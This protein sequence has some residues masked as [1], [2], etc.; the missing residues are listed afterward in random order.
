MV[1]VGLR[2]GLIGCGPR[3]LSVFERL[4]SICEDRPHQPVTIYIFDPH[5]HGSGVHWPKQPDYLLLNTISGQLGVFPDAAALGGLTD[6]RERPGKDFLTWCRG[7][8]IKVDPTSG[9][10]AL[11][12]RDVE[13]EDFLPRG[14]LGAYLAEAFEEILATTPQNVKVF[15]HHKLV[16]TV[17]ASSP[18]LYRLR[19]SSEDSVE[20]DRLILTVGHTG[21]NRA[22]ENGY[23]ENIYPLP[24]SLDTIKSGESVL[25][26][27]LGLG[28]M[29]T[30]AA[31]TSGR[32][33]HYRRSADGNHV[34]SPS[35]K[36]PVIFVQSR[37]GL[38]FRARPDGLTRFPRHKAVVLTKNRIA[39]LRAKA[40]NGR[41]D[42]AQDILPLL[43]IEMRAAAAAVRISK[44]NVEHHWHF[45][46]QLRAIGADENSGVVA[47][48]ALLRHH[49]QSVGLLDLDTLIR[50]KLPDCVNSHNYHAWIYDAIETDLHDAR[51]GLA[52][53]PTKAALEIW[54]DLRDRLRDVVDFDGLT[55][56]SHRQFYGRWN[57]LINR[58]VAGPQKERHAD[59]L[60]LCDAGLLT[61][62]Y[63]GISPATGNYRRVAAYVQG[64]GVINSNCGPVQA[65]AHLGLIRPKIADEGLDGIDVDAAYH[66]KSTQSEPVNNIWVLG[67]LAEGSCYYNHYVS[68]A[69]TPSRLFM[70]AHKVAKDVL[71]VG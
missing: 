3:G 17:E 13:P 57:K 14:L 39:S 28:A 4:L 5:L 67:P 48:E 71:D 21:R 18:H 66:P 31:L 36:E 24:G 40:V 59:L 41:L 33:G 52:E 22:G 38:P 44:A 53:S 56:A 9:L 15:V 49:E 7:R 37:D 34:Y 1:N 10:V 54:R 65:L 12:G 32:G 11:N 2:I 61:F 70:D 29:D 6:A 64:T 69:G 58:F 63:P 60:A 19:T 45:L 51:R 42:F 62:L 35:G 30:L 68:S 50:H 55:E 25:I 20:V 23:I 26:E 47:C 8:A 27:G 46:N 16:T 43:T